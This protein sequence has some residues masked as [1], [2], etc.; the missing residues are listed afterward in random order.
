MKT[1]IPETEFLDYPLII[2][3]F[4]EQIPPPLFPLVVIVMCSFRPKFFQTHRP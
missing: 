1:K 3:Y 4:R 2:W